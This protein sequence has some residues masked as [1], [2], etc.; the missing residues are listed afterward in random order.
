M[1]ESYEDFSETQ[2]K[3]LEQFVSNTSSNVFV[4]TQLA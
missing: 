3:V 1:Q 4:F 2:L